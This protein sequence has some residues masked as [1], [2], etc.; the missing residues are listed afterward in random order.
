MRIEKY[1]PPS[2][3]NFFI[4][5]EYKEKWEKTKSQCFIKQIDKAAVKRFCERAVSAGR[6]VEGRYTAQTVL[7]KFGLVSG[8]HL[9]NAG[10]YSGIYIQ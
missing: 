4:A 5:N 7:K 6:I 9:T 1:H 10:Y 2:L 8:D 3:G